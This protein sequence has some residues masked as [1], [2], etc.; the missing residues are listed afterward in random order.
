MLPPSVTIP[1]AFVHGMV[2]GI[3]ARAAVRR[4]AAG[5]RHRPGLLQQAGARVTADQYVALVRQLIEHLDDRAIGFLSRPLKRG[6]FA[7]MARS[8]WSATRSRWR[9]AAWQSA[10]RLLQDDVLLEPLRDG[11]LAGWR[12]A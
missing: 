6:S 5:R 3:L 7:L 12:C 8:R 4:P 2:S 11:R 1:I 10:F 9:S